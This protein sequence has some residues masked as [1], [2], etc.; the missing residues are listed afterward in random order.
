MKYKI[1]RRSNSNLLEIELKFGETVLADKNT[2][3]YMTPNI[4]VETKALR[5]SNLNSTAGLVSEDIFI[6][7]YFSEDKNEVLCLAPPYP[8]DIEYHEL[9]NDTLY[10]QKDSFLSA[11]GDIEIDTEVGKV[12]TVFSK[13]GIFLLKLNGFGNV[14]L[15]GFGSIIKK[16]LKNEKIIVGAGHLAAFTGE[17]RFNVK[18]ISG[19]RTT[20]QSYEGV[21]VEL[22]GNGTVY[23]Q[24]RNIHSFIELLSP[25]FLKF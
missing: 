10:I 5:M 24:S 12:R 18:R 8:G 16:E 7:V 22:Y 14:F 11:G 3:V 4:R 20:F 2:L 19:F 9:K 23:I 13:E 17:L 21:V 1:I 25:F 6:D 15:S